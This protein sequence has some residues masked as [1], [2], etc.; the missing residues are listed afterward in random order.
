M[1]LKITTQ[2]CPSETLNVKKK[3][4]IE[5]GKCV[6]VHIQSYQTKTH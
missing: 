5:K 4:R 6:H 3:K 2:N 1:A